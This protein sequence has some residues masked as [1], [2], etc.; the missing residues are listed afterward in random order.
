MDEKQ[1]SG[2][3]D[4]LYILSFHSPL[5]IVAGVLIFSVFVSA[6][7]KY[8]AF[9]LFIFI[10]TCLRVAVLSI[11]SIY[12]QM[13]MII[14]PTKCKVGLSETFIP[15]DVT[16]SSYM[17]AATMFYFLMPMILV[18]SENKINAINYYILLFFIA[19]ILLDLFIKSSLLCIPTVF[20]V[21]VLSEL[22][23]GSLLGALIASLMYYYTRNLLFINETNT[24]KEVCSMPTKQQFKCSVYK[25]GE[26]VSS[27]I[28]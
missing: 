22:A 13:K 20:S 6:I 4:L 11:P 1:T 24:N 26:L 14:L 25:N 8:G 7:P 28:S 2:L 15:N 17:L 9:L 27:S 23:A 10:I 19:Y 21:G 18:S 12:N 3:T 5:I 16:Y